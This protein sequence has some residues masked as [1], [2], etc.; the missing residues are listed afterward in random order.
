MRLN[1]LWGLGRPISCIPQNEL[2]VVAH[3]PEHRVVEQMPRHVLD[4]GGV[5]REHG[6]RV[7]VALTRRVAVDVPQA[8]GVVVWGAEKVAVHVRVPGQ[9]VAFLAVT[10]LTEIMNI[11]IY[12]SLSFISWPD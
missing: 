9:T 8:D 1:N 11:Y 7:Q 5:A 3:R 2:F 12:I 6:Q 4:H 10:F